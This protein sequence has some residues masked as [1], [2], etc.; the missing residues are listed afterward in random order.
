MFVCTYVEAILRVTYTEY[1][2]GSRKKNS[3]C[4]GP[5]TK[6]L[7]PPPLSSLV[8]T[9]FPETFFSTLKKSSFPLLVVWPLKTEY[10]LVAS[11]MQFKEYILIHGIK[12][13]NTYLTFFSKIIY[14][15]NRNKNSVEIN[16][17]GWII[18]MIVVYIQEILLCNIE[19]KTL[20]L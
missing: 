9:F 3:F 20:Q 10:F 12:M 6:A 8:V 15:L 2:K 13:W 18:A 19:L 17:R 11:Q 4:S 14:H 5:A 7:I 16:F 1:S